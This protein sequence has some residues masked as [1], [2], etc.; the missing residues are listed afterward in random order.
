[1]V[2]LEEPCINLKETIV[3]VLYPLCA[4]HMFFR[5]Q[6]KPKVALALASARYVVV[7]QACE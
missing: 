2:M 3:T 6:K 7:S 5:A 4:C 1:V